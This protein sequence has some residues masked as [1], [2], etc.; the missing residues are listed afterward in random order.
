MICIKKLATVGL[1]RKSRYI[2]RQKK[3]S[4]VCIPFDQTAVNFLEEIG[5]S[6]YKV[7][8]PE[9]TDIGL[10]ETLSKTGKPIILSHW[11]GYQRRY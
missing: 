6:A 2:S 11:R 4:L 9:I 7:A 1:D 5:C 3:V 8:S 10:I